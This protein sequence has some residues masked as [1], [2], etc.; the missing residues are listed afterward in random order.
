MNIERLSLQ[1][2]IDYLATCISLLPALRERIISSED[3]KAYKEI[4][5]QKRGNE[6]GISTPSKLDVMCADYNTLDFT[7][8]FL[9]DLMDR[10]NR[11]R[12]S[13]DF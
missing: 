7:L 12:N 13:P 3:Y 10:M 4:V 11:E 6:I 5:R 1:D 8:Q 9:Y 2:K